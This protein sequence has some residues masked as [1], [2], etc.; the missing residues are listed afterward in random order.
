MTLVVS[1]IERLS[2]HAENIIEYAQQVYYKKAKLSTVAVEELRELAE[3]VMRSVDLCITIF[4]EEKYDL[5]PQAE[6]LEQQVD[7]K[8]KQIVNN[9]VQRLMQA[10]CDPLG[11]VV[12]T[13]M[14]SDLERCSDHAINIACATSDE[15]DY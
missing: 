5:I 7:D 3:M 10:Q 1:D 2:D 6:A 11:G 4:E 14:S 15:P 8:Q 12:F 13:D 9:H